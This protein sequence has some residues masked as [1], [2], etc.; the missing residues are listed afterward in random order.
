MPALFLPRILRKGLM[1][2]QTSSTWLPHMHML[3]ICWPISRNQTTPHQLSQKVTNYQQIHAIAVV[4]I[5]YWQFHSQQVPQLLWLSNSNLNLLTWQY[6]H[7]KC[8]TIQWRPAGS[9]KCNVQ[10]AIVVGWCLIYGLHY[11]PLRFHG[12]PHGGGTQ[13]NA[14]HEGVSGKDWHWLVQLDKTN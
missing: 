11:L 2:Y 1:N 7:L 14:I 6:S 10:V 8:T 5:G 4:V 3:W 13:H 9:W 12:G